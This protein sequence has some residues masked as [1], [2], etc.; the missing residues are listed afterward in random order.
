MLPALLTTG[1]LPECDRFGAW[2]E[3][4]RRTYVPLEVTPRGAA[5]AF[6]GEIALQ[7]LGSLSLSVLK[8][9]GQQA[10]RTRAAIARAEGDW[11][12]VLGQIGGRGTV[13]QDARETRLGPGGWAIVDTTRP[14]DLL[15]DAGFEQ[16]VVSVPRVLLPALLQRSRILTGQDLSG[17][18][19]PGRGLAQQLALLHRCA[20]DSDGAARAALAESTLD[21]LSATI[22]DTLRECRTGSVRQREQLARIEAF[23]WQRLRD[24]SLDVGVIAG[25]FGLSTRYVHRLFEA[26]GVPVS[27]YIRRLRL[28]NCC[29]DL[30]DARLCHLGITHIAFGWGFNSASHFSTLF[31][32]YYGV[33]A[34]EYRRGQTPDRE[35]A[36]GQ[37]CIPIHSRPKSATAILT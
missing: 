29:R 14:Y 34:G 1:N 23:I 15:F 25:A 9:C 5:D 2:Q 35:A 26:D 24:G 21:L 33:S 3:F 30:R 32:H 28:D 37:T 10:T 22:N 13:R 31:R 11:F 4:V 17:A 7:T 6:F 12:F 20:G 27:E 18:T 8:S 36:A 16:I 19:P